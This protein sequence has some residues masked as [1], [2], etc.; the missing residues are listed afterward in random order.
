MTIHRSEALVQARKVCR[1]IASAPLPQARAREFFQ[2]LVRAEG[3]TAAQQRNIVE[4]GG[5][6]E[7]RP[8]PGA[9]RQRCEQLLAA[10]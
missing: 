6:L 8:A 5:W 4:L 2:I 1:T 10:L 3:W 9:L 7:T